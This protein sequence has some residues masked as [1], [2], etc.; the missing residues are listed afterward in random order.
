M[1]QSSEAEMLILGCQVQDKGYTIGVL[2]GNVAWLVD[3]VASW[4]DAFGGL[5]TTLKSEQL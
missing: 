1:G 3:T 5:E 4:N 2:P